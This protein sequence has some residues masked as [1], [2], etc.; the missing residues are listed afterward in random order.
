MLKKLILILTFCIGTGV[1]AEDW[2]GSTS[3]PSSK[4]VDGVEYY[5]IT[6]PSELAWFAY[7]VTNNGKINFRTR[8]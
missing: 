6:S 8:C 3:K 2:D 7:Q 1:F 5:V 4:T